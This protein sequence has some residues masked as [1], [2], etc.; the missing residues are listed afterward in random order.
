MAPKL[1]SDIPLGKAGRIM[2]TKMAVVRFAASGDVAASPHSSPFGSALALYS[3]SPP[4]LGKDEARGRPTRRIRFP[5]KKPTKS[6]SQTRETWLAPTLRL[7]QPPR[8][9][10]HEL[11]G[12]PAHVGHGLS[13][14]GVKEGLEDARPLICEVA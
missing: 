3:L 11:R 13:L 8:L 7:R 9:A 1:L 4:N 10:A 14:R 12:P 6:D 2:S 5:G